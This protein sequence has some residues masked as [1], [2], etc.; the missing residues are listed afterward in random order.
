MCV[1]CMA[2]AMA[3]VGTASGLRA[4]LGARFRPRLGD[5][6]LRRLTVGLFAAAVVASGL[7]LG[8]SG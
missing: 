7:V 4:W 5:R 3:S 2:T 1:Q 8:G 6:G